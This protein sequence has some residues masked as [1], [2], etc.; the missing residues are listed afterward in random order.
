MHLDHILWCS[1]LKNR[2]EIPL[3]VLNKDYNLSYRKLR[4]KYV[5]LCLF[6]LIYTLFRQISFR[7]NQQIHLKKWILVV[8]N[9]ALQ[10]MGKQL[11]FS[12]LG[13]VVAIHQCPW[14]SC[15]WHFPK[16]GELWFLPSPVEDGDV[17]DPACSD[18]RTHLSPVRDHSCCF[19]KVLQV[20]KT[21]GRHHLQQ[22]P[23]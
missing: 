14:K 15:G 23:N 21:S 3:S 2:Y 4:E 12:Y 7:N 10:K 22:G 11:I 6:L 18:F 16:Q 20:K 9:P 5:C 1:S 8:C 19:K 17:T 13:P